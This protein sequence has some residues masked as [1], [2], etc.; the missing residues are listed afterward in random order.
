MQMMKPKSTNRRR[1]ISKEKPQVALFTIILIIY[2]LLA[3]T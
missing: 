1:P 3:M 2:M